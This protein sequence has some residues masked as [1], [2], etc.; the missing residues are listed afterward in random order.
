V[1][2]TENWNTRRIAAKFVPRLLKK[3][4]RTAARERVSWVM[5]E[6]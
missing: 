3:L 2:L 6:G 1:I 4:C 5:I